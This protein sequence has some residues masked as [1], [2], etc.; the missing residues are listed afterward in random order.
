MNQHDVGSSKNNSKVFFTLVGTVIFGVFSLAGIIHAKNLEE[1]FIYKED[2]RLSAARESIYKTECQEPRRQQ[3]RLT[4]QLEEKTGVA[5]L[6]MKSYFEDGSKGN[7]L[8]SYGQKIVEGEKYVGEKCEAAIKQVAN[9][10]R[11]SSTEFVIT[12]FFGRK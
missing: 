12:N 5:A 10:K 3:E 11:G 8:Y 6:R 7:E 4:A 1:V 9:L 2:N